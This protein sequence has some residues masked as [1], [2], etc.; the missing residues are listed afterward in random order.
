MRAGLDLVDRFGGKIARTERFNARRAASAE[1]HLGRC[2][3]AGGGVMLDE[4]DPSRNDT[5][6]GRIY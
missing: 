4:F 2:E 6:G 5:R 1:A 3:G